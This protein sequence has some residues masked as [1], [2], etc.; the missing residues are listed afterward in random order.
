VCKKG[1]KGQLRSLKGVQARIF[2]TDPGGDRSGEGGRVVIGTIPL[3]LK[4]RKENT[5]C[6]VGGGDL[7]LVGKKEGAAMSS[8]RVSPTLLEK[9]R[10]CYKNGG[11]G[12]KLRDVKEST[13]CKKGLARKRQRLV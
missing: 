5:L 9:S 1:K 10:N 7:Y 8:H 6:P 4:A 3:K 2:A 13:S 12:K 11:F